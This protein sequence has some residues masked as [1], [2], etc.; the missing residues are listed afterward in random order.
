MAETVAQWDETAKVPH[1]K[2]IQVV[3]VGQSA[4]FVAR[5]GPIYY[6]QP[7]PEIEIEMPVSEMKKFLLSA[8][9]SLREK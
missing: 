1:P 9:R 7:G 2:F 3:Q 6:A 8:M 5:G 4:K